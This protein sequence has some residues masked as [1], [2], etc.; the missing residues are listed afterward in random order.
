MSKRISSGGTPRTGVSNYYGGD[1]PW[2]RTQE[3]N[4]TEIWDTEVKLSPEGFAASSAKWIPENSVIVAMYGAT[5]GRVGI[6]K[7]PITTNQACANIEVDEQ[8]ANY[9]YV[10]HY[11]YSQYPNIKAMGQGVQ[12]NI[13]LQ[14]VRQIPIPLPS[15]SE[16]ERI[17][18]ILDRFEALAHSMSE[19]L[20]REIALRRQQ[21]EHYRHELLDFA[22]PQS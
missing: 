1:I 17:V 5:V 4:F 11:L 20:P 9:R 2:L 7:V 8:Q 13:S 18:G 10:F 12:S 19:G 3:V 15:L 22:R 14:I 21:Y 6:N 16:Q